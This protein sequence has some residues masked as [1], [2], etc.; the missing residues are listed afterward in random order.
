DLRARCSSIDGRYELTAQPRYGLRQLIGAPRRFAEPEWNG[1]RLSMRVFD[2]DATRLD[3]LNAVGGIAELKDVAGHTLDREILVDRA[4]Q[5][6]RRLQHDVVV[7]RVGNRA[8]RG[9][10]RETRAAP[11]AQHAVNR[12]AMDIGRTVTVPRAVAVGH[13]PHD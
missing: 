3:A 5:L 7:G 11:P 4:D 2:A 9:Q 13:D 8:A 12:V 10:G 6:T 1:G